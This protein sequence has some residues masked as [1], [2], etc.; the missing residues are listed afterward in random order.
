VRRQLL[1]GGTVHRLLGIGQPKSC[2]T[3]IFAI[4]PPGRLSGVGGYLGS[5]VFWV[6]VLAGTAALVFGSGCPGPTRTTHMEAM[7]ASE[8]VS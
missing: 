6:V 7:E 5:Y 1:K 3:E 2:Q 4:T 8:A